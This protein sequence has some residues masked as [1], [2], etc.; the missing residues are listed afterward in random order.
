MLY[1]KITE[2]IILTLLPTFLWLQFFK[3]K[4]YNQEPNYILR[5]IFI[6]SFL[7]TPL[8]GLFQF[9]ANENLKTALGYLSFL[10]F[11]CS[12]INKSF[13]S[14]DIPFVITNLFFL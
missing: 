12:F 10:N 1:L 13:F 8:V 6:L 7:F 11:N 3:G 2:I 14:L 4:D 5:R 9:C